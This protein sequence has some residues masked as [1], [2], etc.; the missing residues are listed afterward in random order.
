[1]KHNA[2]QILN[3]PLLQR[4]TGVLTNLRVRIGYPGA[5]F[6]GYGIGSDPML[7]PTIPPYRDIR[8]STYLISR[9]LQHACIKKSSIS[10]ISI[11][12]TYKLE[13]T[14]LIPSNHS[15]NHI[16]TQGQIIAAITAITIAGSMLDTLIFLSHTRFRPMQKMSIDPT[17]ER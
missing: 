1:M 12:T 16:F 8:Y 7:S 2:P 3:P 15:S 4:K 9:L 17:R 5:T 13:S 11:I 10:H 14:V 6:Q